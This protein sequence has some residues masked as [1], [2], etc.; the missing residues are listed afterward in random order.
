MYVQ[1]LKS[2]DNPNLLLL[3]V[4]DMGR[5]A[6]QRAALSTVGN[7]ITEKNTF[8]LWNALS[9]HLLSSANGQSGRL[10]YDWTLHHRQ[11]KKKKEKKSPF[12]KYDP[13][14]CLMCALEHRLTTWASCDF[15]FFFFS[16]IYRIMCDFVRRG[17][18][19]W[20]KDHS[21]FQCCE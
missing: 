20:S 3:A 16:C 4:N 14:S 10:R 21:L 18:D 5:W 12:Q 11:G 9:E 1:V 19:C 15:F 2:A 17:R 8:L 7:K 13:A 6:F